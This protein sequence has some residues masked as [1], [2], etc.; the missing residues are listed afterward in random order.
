MV[1]GASSSTGSSG[2]SGVSGTSGPSGVSGVSWMPPS[3]RPASVPGSSSSFV[4]PCFFLVSSRGRCGRGLCPGPCP[5][6]SAGQQESAVYGKQAIHGASKYKT[7]Q[8][9]PFSLCSPG[10]DGIMITAGTAEAVVYGGPFSVDRGRGAGT[11]PLLLALACAL[12]LS[13]TTFP[14]NTMSFALFMGIFSFS[15]AVLPPG[16]QGRRWSAKK[17]PAA[18]PENGT[19]RRRCLSGQ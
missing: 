18:G 3:P 15:P 1:I 11:T 9:R 2:V 6:S 13:Y 4:P 14:E 10:K 12:L 8:N 17:A 16:G 5:P 7:H 19:C